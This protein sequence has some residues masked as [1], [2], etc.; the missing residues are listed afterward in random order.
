MWAIL[1][2]LFCSKMLCTCLCVP[3]VSYGLVCVGNCALALLRTCR[4]KS[5]VRCF[6]QICDGCPSHVSSCHA[7]SK[8]SSLLL[9]RTLQTRNPRSTTLPDKKQI[10]QL[11]V[12]LQL[13]KSTSL[14]VAPQDVW[15]FGVYR[16]V[17]QLLQLLILLQLLASTSSS[18]APQDVRPLRRY[19][20]R[21]HKAAVTAYL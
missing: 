2:W 14:S 1:L 4:T 17:W 9:R 15:S 5:K 13:L 7:A 12:L 3:Y 6:Y 19:E 20:I 16:E 10:L 11:L 8:Q 18:A 21:F